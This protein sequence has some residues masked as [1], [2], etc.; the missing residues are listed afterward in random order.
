VIDL[1]VNFEENA[2]PD[3]NECEKDSEDVFVA[4]S[5]LV[6]FI[7]E[8]R[9]P[10]HINITDKGVGFMGIETSRFSTPLSLFPFIGR[11]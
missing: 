3:E 4:T 10:F 2:Y 8:G 11:L 7:N 5:S 9:F 1:N 6:S